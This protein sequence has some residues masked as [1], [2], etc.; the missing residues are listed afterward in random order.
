MFSLLD[1]GQEQS[2]IDVLLSPPNAYGTFII[3]QT[4]SVN[5]KL[6]N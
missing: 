1:L 2:K 5:S 3:R 6:D 4:L